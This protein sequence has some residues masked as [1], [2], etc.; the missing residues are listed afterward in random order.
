[1]HVPCDEAFN[2]LDCRRND[3][4]HCLLVASWRVLIA[5]VSQ[6]FRMDLVAHNRRHSV[7]GTK[8]IDLAGVDFDLVR[9]KKVLLDLVVHGKK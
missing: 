4:G 3:V 6:E 9:D 8:L 5:G 1:M 7:L 2:T